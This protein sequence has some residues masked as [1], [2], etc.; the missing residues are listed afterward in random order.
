MAKQYKVIAQNG[1]DAAKEVLIEQGLGA[2]GQ[3]VRIKAEAGV[4]YVLEDLQRDKPVGPDYVKVRRNGKNLLV[5]FAGENEASLIL[6]NYY[7]VMPAGHEGLIGQAENGKYYPYIPEDPKTTG[8]VPLLSDGAQAVNVALGNAEVIPF[9]L[10]SGG[11]PAPG[12][13]SSWL[14]LLG[15]AAIAALAKDGDSGPSTPT[16]PQAPVPGAA[17]NIIVTSDKDQLA[18][19]QTATITFKLSEAS[20]DFV[21]GDV[22]VVGGTLSNFTGSGATYTATF[23]PTAGATSA[24]ILVGSGSFRNAT[25]S[26]NDDGAEANNTVAL[27]IG[28]PVIGTPDEKVEPT[29]IVTSNKTQLATGDTAT[30]TFDLSVDSTDF[31]LADVTAVGGSLSNFQGSGTRYTATFTPADSA[32]GG[33]VLVASDRFTDGAGNA[34]KDGS[35]TNNAV[36]LSLGASE[37]INSGTGGITGGGDDTAPPTV[38]V[39]TS[40]KQLATGD[41]AVIS[42]TLSEPSTDFSLADVTLV[43]GTLSN[44]N[45]TGSSYTATFTPT[46]GATSGAIVVA[47]ST[48]SDAAGN[49]NADGQ[50]INNTVSLSIGTGTGTDT[51]PPTVIVAS[52][53]TSLA[54][55]DTANITF[56][57]S[58]TSTNFSAADVTVVGG[59]LSNFSGSGTTYTATFT[60]TAGATSGTIVVASNTFS[61]AA[62]NFNADGQ[63]ANNTVSFSLGNA[64]SGGTSG[65]TA[66]PTIIVASNKTNL[67]TG[68]TANITFTLSEAST[69]FSLTD[70]TVVGGTLAN[71]TGSGTSYN[72]IFTPNAGVSSAAIVVASN[73]FKDAANNFNADGAEPNN[74]VSMSVGEFIAQDGGNTTT[75]DLT[76]PTIVVSSNKTN[77]TTGETALINFTLSEPSTNFALG[78]V[79][80]IGGTLSNL[81]GSGT[82]YTATFTPTNGATGAA[83]LVPSSSFTD[84]AGN[85][86]ADG[87]EVNNAVALSIGGT[88]AGP[89]PDTTPPTVIVASNKTGLSAGETATIS[90]T[91]SETSSN[92]GLSDVNV[93]GG[94]LSNFQGAGTS[95]IATF[96]PT[97]G[98]SSGLIQVNSDQFTDAAGNANKDGAEP[99]NGVTL[100]L[101]L[102]AGT[103]GN[104]PNLADTTPPT[105]I[106]TSNKANLASGE[107]AT[108]SFNLSEASNN[109][110]LSDVTTVGGQL[111]NFSGSG[112]SFSATFTPSSGATSGAIVVASNTFSDA[113]GNTNGDGGEPNNAVAL[114]IAPP[115]QGGTGTSPGTNTTPPT[116]VVSSNKTALA[117][118]E[119][120]TISFSLSEPSLNFAVNDV[121]VIGGTL[122]NFQGLGSNYTATFTPTAGVTAAAI[123]VASNTFS[124][125]AAKFNQDGADA[126]NAVAL[127]IGAPAAPGPAGDTTPPTVIVNSNKTT[128]ATGETA[129]I[130]FA[131]SEASTN[132]S[133]D[134]V[135][136][137]GGTLSNFT[138]SGTSYS[139][140]FTPSSNANSAAILVGSGVFSDAAGNFNA[141]GAE[142]NNTVS[143]SLG[144]ANGGATTGDTVAPTIV[145]SSNKTALVTGETATIS[146][147]LSE[148]SLNFAVSDVTVIGGTLSNFQG[149]GSNYTATFTPTAGATSAAIVVASNSFS[150]A[151]ANFNQDGSEANNAVALSIG[152]PVTPGPAGD[153]TPPTVIV[154][155]NKTTLATGETATISFTLSEA[156][157]NF[158][159]GDVSVVGG[160]LSNF[161][162]SGTS[163]SATFTPNSSTNS[164]AI[165]VASGT[166]S[167]AAGNFNTDGAESNNT[168]S[169][170]IGTPP[171]PTDTT[172]PT[173]IVSASKTNLT[174]GETATIS[175][176]LSETSTDFNVSDITVVGGTLNN[177]A[178]SGTS[179]TATFTPTSGATSG[180]V[181][182]SSTTFRDAAG[183]FNADGQEPNNAVALSIGS[184]TA[185]PSSDTTPPTVIVS[186]NK[187]GLAAGET[188][189]ISFTLSESSSNF[190]LSDITVI[191]GTL[192]NFQGSGTS[193]IATFTPNAGSSSGLIMVDSDR[194]TDAAGNNN[195]DGAEPNNGVSI[196]LGLPLG[197]SGLNTLN[198]AD[199]TPPTIIVSSNKSTLATGE[200]ATISFNM[201][202]PSTNFALSDVTVVGGKLSNF[203]GSGTSYTATFT[204][205][206]GSNSAAILV[207]SNT[208]SDAAGNTNGDGQEPNNAVALS[209]TPAPAGTGTGTVGSTDTAP[210]TIIVSSDKTTLT[211][212]ETAT[213]SFNLSEP[214]T[215]FS[216]NDIMVL[217]GSLSNFQGLGTSYTATF[218]PTADAASAAI[219]VASNTFRDA[220]ANFNQDGTE[221]NNAVSLSVTGDEPVGFVTNKLGVLF[222]VL[223]P[224]VIVSSNKTALNTGETAAISF[225]LSE[226]STDFNV[227]DVTVVGGTL[228]N[229]SGS[230]DLYTATFTPTAGTTSAAIVV[231]SNTFTDDSGNTNQDGQESNNVVS[232]SMTAPNSGGTGGGTITPPA[233]TTPPTVIV[234]SNRSQLT[235]GD[236]ATIS[237][238]L[239]EAS[240]NFALGDVT[241]IGGTLSN[242]IGSGASYSATFTPTSGATTATVQVASNTFSD[243]AGNNNNDGAE[244][245]NS[246]TLTLGQAN[247]G[248][249]TPAPTDTTPPTVIVSASKTNLA[250]G[251]TVTINFGL[252]ENSS[253][254]GLGDITVIGGTLSNFTGSGTSYSASFTP[255]PGARSGA[256]VVSSGVF[257]DATGNNNADGLDAN[258]AVALSIG[259]AAAG[260]NP[261]TTPPTVIVSSNKTGL[262][263]GDTATISFSLS[264]ASNNFGPSDINV[265][266]GTLSNF[267]GSGTSYIATFTPNTGAVSGLILVDSD[268]FTD[269]A[270]N[271]NKD[272]A[273]PNNGV[274]ISLG[275]PAGT[276]DLETPNQGDTTPPTVIVSSN[277]ITLT[278][279]E[280]ATISF[281]LSEVSSNFS[282]S[283]ITVI[284]GQLSNF[285]GSGT[286]YTTTFT[287]NAGVTGAAIVVA[288]NAFS[289]AAGNTNGD[290]AEPNNAVALGITAPP[291]AGTGTGGTT[292]PGDTVAP[293]IIVSSNKTNLASG[294]TA[295]ISFTLSE[296]SNTFALNDVL[297]VGGTLSNLQGSGTSYT[298]T[299]TPTAGAT[300][301]A[302]V[303][304]SNTFNDAAGNFN[305]DGSEPNNAVAL[306]LGAVAPTGTGGTGSSTPP[307]DNTPPT[308][309]ITS[310]KSQLAAGETATISFTLSETSTDFSLSD[311]TVVGGSLSNFSGSGTSYTATFTPSAGTT[312]AAV[313]VSSGRFSDA[314]GNFNADGAEPNNAVALSMSATTPGGNGGTTPPA[315]TVAPTVAVTSNKANLAPGETATISFTLSEP[316]SNFNF[317]DITVVGGSLSNFS[318][319][320]TSYTAT[321]TPTV[322]ATGGAIVVASSR[323]SDAAGNFNAD[324]AE[325]NNAVSLSL[326]GTNPSTPVSAG[327]GGTGGTTTGSADTTP[328]TIAVTCDKDGV[329]AGDTATVS[330]TLSEPSNNFG[331]NDVTVIGGTL[332]NFR[333]S[334]TS[335]VATFTP[336]VGATSAAIMVASNR[337]SDTSGNFNTDGAEPNN[338]LT[339]SI[340]TNLANPAAA[341]LDTVPP[342]I[343]VTS[344]L[345]NLSVGQTAT[346]SF[347]LSEPSTNFSLGDVTVVGGSLSNFTGS[348]TSYTATFT[349]TAGATGAAIVVASNTF[350]DA[351]GNTNDDGSEPNNAVALS[352]ATPTG[353]SGS[354]TGTTP[355]TLPPSIAVT[356][357]QTN[358]SPGQTST[359]SFSLSEPSTS[360][361]LGDVTVLGG[362]LSNFQGSGT[363]YTATFTPN[364]GATSGVVLVSSG[365]FSDAAGNFNA[366]GSEPNNAL[367]LNISTSATGGTGTTA[368][369]NP[370]TIALTTNK[371]MLDTGETAT[372]SF[373]LSETSIDFSLA[374][375]TTIGGT[376]SNF[377]GSGTSHTATFTPTVGA[378]GAA[379]LVSSGRFSDAAGNFNADGAEPNNTVALSMRTVDSGNGGTTPPADT[380]APTVAVTSNKA[381]LAPGETAT[382]SFTL[383]ETSSNFGPSD[384]TVIGGALSNFQGSGTSYSATFTPSAGASSAAIMVA[385]GGFSDVSGNFNTD[386]AEANNALSL[387]IG[388]SVVNPTPVDTTPPSIAISAST[389]QLTAGQ[390]TTVTFTLSEAS[391][392]FALSDITVVGGTLSNFQGNGT[393]YTATFT[394]TPGAT[395]ATVFVPS[396]SFTDAAGNSNADGAQANNTLSLSL[397]TG[398]GGTDTDTTSPTIAITCDTK[399]VLLGQT[400]TVYFTLSEPSTT[401]GLSDITVMGGTLSNFQGSGTNYTATFTPLPDNYSAAIYVP[402]GKFTNA[403]G[404][405]N[406][407]GGDD[408]NALSLGVECPCDTVTSFTATKGGFSYVFE[409]TSAGDLNGD[410]LNDLIYNVRSTNLAAPLIESYVVFGGMSDVTAAVFRSSS[411][412]GLDT[413]ALSGSNQT[414]DFA[415]TG[416]GALQNIEEIDLTGTGNNLLHLNMNDMLSHFGGQDVYNSS[417][418]TGLAAYEGKTQLMVSGN[419]GDQV[420]LNDLMQWT[421]AS[422]PVVNQGNTYV[423]YNH[424]SVPAQLLIEQA[425]LV[426]AA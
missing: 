17:P 240:S 117:T 66:P 313:L 232:L 202:E 104:T 115:A 144:N 402:S 80:V 256:I 219:V 76:P 287:P 298:A 40:K 156:S 158:N 284:G 214:S 161:T 95:Y 246:V 31:S 91:L 211:T 171:S 423:A 303:V 60:P 419:Q 261:D 407:D 83:I 267:Q 153:T 362:T 233:D 343:A 367:A 164:A 43:G 74:T 189:T 355:D 324:G 265:I 375:V 112:T 406:Q 334:G 394:P 393:S 203:I 44:F 36:T 366:D 426:T 168:V 413:L 286:S 274:S 403:A 278:T 209:I 82:S 55:G 111:S 180:A 215:D 237:F 21:A 398:T 397:S 109:F 84:A 357:N 97:A 188:A 148:P 382:I 425:L 92:F 310:S 7:E 244:P 105:I 376:L 399:M 71:F 196:S 30:I 110:A 62:A 424:N 208:F 293:T 114:S 296:N 344:N 251:E 259:S 184:A 121:T 388:T 359:I 93:T 149:S 194:F 181:M 119:T 327:T 103:G 346:I 64:S 34:N 368:D 183:N 145:V 364:T 258:N 14:P 409:S 390:S 107:T 412:T 411:N 195:Q 175:F 140:T 353:T 154:S 421:A 52:N 136:V 96:T 301:A 225:N 358:L 391:S 163:Y 420:I 371:A 292:P 2:R 223:P 147:A 234:S 106:V 125:A 266:G 281:N 77:L 228:S 173:V 315:D 356:S 23:T 380:V 192:S 299:F 414:L 33:A 167:D 58:E 49:F 325:P 72:A 279:G 241:V 316:S 304:A 235:S 218:T 75:G 68:E 6:E 295:T 160:A 186:S 155:S 142:S 118:G 333:G 59:T 247:S 69:D 123:V 57:L 260:P 351:A 216:L 236:T 81:Q 143:L 341:N 132:F 283:D 257:S 157:T 307:A 19:G 15:M 134:D 389:N 243:A 381:N 176:N 410:S 280:T 152:A 289:D 422:T 377:T 323:F 65:D 400:P 220:A 321:F 126:N 63:E 378:T 185:G 263:T 370:P 47:S 408:N 48:F 41:T 207:A 252:S 221:P 404:N 330:F 345:S 32:K 401:F 297:V 102:P 85:P 335:Y 8:L 20:T 170:S 90:F 271:N 291:T 337:F 73:T 270:G 204:P 5:I 206:A 224:T 276:T 101:G 138:G 150:D 86:N 229:F 320:G 275:L 120:A 131:L 363:S 385:S 98:A 332:S 42:F 70:V 361:S 108:I 127:S 61:D 172:P 4:K 372:I 392:S 198:P 56:T 311:I 79:T 227:D 331:Q 29:V 339:L 340:G 35:E 159:I 10:P 18:P 329:A 100:S 179:Y 369:I 3:P 317:S 248:G 205:T 24:A 250:L 26:R 1:K 318:G 349:P 137:V 9:G 113:A 166:F 116:I 238:N 178:G 130:S 39:S 28:T 319:S 273:E 396:G 197:T 200:T 78:G 25:G 387:S 133:I 245:N 347:T 326:G 46:A 141:D 290:G 373:T 314:A 418:S 360:F 328:P 322:G 67:A 12:S 288:S 213:I 255:T 151:A 169:L 38:I 45:G 305:T 254:F 350:S 162:G 201:T 187:L 269:A 309:A 379:V 312:G 128:L 272:G 135:T 383:S 50:E 230:G 262:V 146:F 217:G 386:G 306:S 415:Q 253:N 129:T 354:G 405:V 124:D 242:L 352:I 285:Q 338:A 190:G 348:G 302:I 300:S 374:D 11:S 89:N 395:N 294:E 165:V 222:D 226:Q 54:T 13:L 199:T 88:A 22:T 249:G 384:V 308:I 417:N 342:T 99:N 174:L 212:G 239:S 191:G 264:E 282:L 87:K 336:N 94:T 177:F 193:Y 51:T 231:A 365:S 210:P 268:R 27:K 16:S 182:V 53:K 139:A 37:S 122:S 277:K 416:V